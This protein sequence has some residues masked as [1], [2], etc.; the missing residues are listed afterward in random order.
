MGKAQQQPTLMCKAQQPI[1]GKEQQQPQVHL[2]PDLPE[3]RG[4]ACAVPGTTDG[5]RAPPN[6][7]S[8]AGGRCGSPDLQKGALA[9]L[10]TAVYQRVHVRDD[11]DRQAMEQVSAE[12]RRLS[13]Q[14][15][16]ELEVQVRSY[17]CLLCAQG[18]PDH[19]SSSFTE[20]CQPPS[21][22]T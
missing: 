21:T 18:G 3:H 10:F 9:T 17:R 7:A 12:L 14:H 22:S 15:Y 20:M 6:G 19:L 4:G 1:M 2:Q 13:A 16:E 11:L 5:G 8:P